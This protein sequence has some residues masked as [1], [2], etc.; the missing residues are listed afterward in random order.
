M[1]KLRIAVIFGGYSNEHEVSK[2]SGVTVLEGL[3]PNK[4]DIIPI[5][6]DKN[7]NWFLADIA[8]LE[9]EIDTSNLK[10]VVISPSRGDKS[11]LTLDDNHYTKIPIDIAFPALLGKFGE[12]G[13]I[14]GMFEIMGIPYVGCGVL[15]SSMSMDKVYTNDIAKLINMPQPDYLAY[16]EGEEIDYQEIVDKLGLPCFVKAVRSG[17]SVGIFKP[18]TI[19]ALVDN[20]TEAFKYDN[21]IIIERNINGI[22]L[23]CAVLG[24]G[25][26]DTVAS[27]SGATLFEEGLAFYDYN[28]KYHS[29]ETRKVIPAEVPEEIHQKVQ[30]LSLQIFKALDCSGLARADFFWEDETGHILFNEINTFPAFTEVSMYP[31]LCKHMGYSLTVLLDKLI[32]I[33][34]KTAR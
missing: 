17:S 19:E 28:A 4:Y 27:Y 5:Y 1:N 20:V 34:L 10:P 30:E 18:E 15:A 24:S 29:S 11:I 26:D 9:T 12:D 31:A 13:T 33:G 22:E 25:G 7:G 8:H 3:N 6:I 32:E 23:K 16:K 2:D 21:K 14:Q